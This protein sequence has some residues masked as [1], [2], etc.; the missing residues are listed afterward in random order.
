MFVKPCLVRIRV[1]GPQDSLLDACHVQTAVQYSVC[2]SSSAVLGELIGSTEP[3]KRCMFLSYH[4][5]YGSCCVL[6]WYSD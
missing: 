4:V 6:V 2:C 5:E 3:Y 1:L